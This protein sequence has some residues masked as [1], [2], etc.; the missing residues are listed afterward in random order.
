MLGCTK[1]TEQMEHIVVS[2]STYAN[3]IWAALRAAE[4]PLWEEK[5]QEEENKPPIGWVRVPEALFA[6]DEFDSWRR[7]FKYDSENG[8]KVPINQEI[9]DTL[10]QASASWDCSEDVPREV[11]VAAA[12]AWFKCLVLGESEYWCMTITKQ[13]PKP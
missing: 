11:R 9:F 8:W 1:D 7:H 13:V 4:E 5:K 3:E 12:I 6:S 2:M 10:D